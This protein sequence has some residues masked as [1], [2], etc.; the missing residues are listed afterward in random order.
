MIQSNFLISWRRFW[1]LCSI[2]ILAGCI[3]PQGLTELPELNPDSEQGGV[4]LDLSP[5]PQ[6][7]PP[8]D[9]DAAELLALGLAALEQGDLQLAQSYMDQTIALDAYNAHAYQVRGQVYAAL[10]LPDLAIANFSQAMALDT[11][12]ADP[13]FSRGL[14]LLDSGNFDSA[15][16]DFNA[17]ITFEPTYAEA[18]KYRAI[19]EKELGLIDAALLDFELYLT[20]NPNA[21]DQVE[22]LYMMSDLVVLIEQANALPDGVLFLDDFSDADTGWI[23]GSSA[24][25]FGDF[26]SGGYRIIVTI[27]ESAI[28]ARPTL[29]LRDVR[30]EVDATKSGGP[31]NN[32]FGVLCRY[33]SSENFYALIISS[34]GFY[35]IAQRINGGGLELIGMAEMPHS[36]VINPGAASNRILAECVGD[37]LRLTVNG[38][39][40]LEI[41]DS[42]LNAGDVGIIAG[43]F[44]EPRTNI[45]FDNFTVFEVR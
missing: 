7:T 31:D 36:N 1:G 15:R 2:V 19:T 17:A 13:Y 22:V 12:Y 21:A 43:A 40:L 9:A 5:E 38:V 26:D 11:N 6:A 20:M 33:Q 35:G 41:R 24:P 23:G 34:D 10:G 42:K 3:N 44:L 39:A 27:A 29:W 4:I 25:G 45:L 16:L 28:W 18:Y 8:E 37:V 32:F 30:I 14:I